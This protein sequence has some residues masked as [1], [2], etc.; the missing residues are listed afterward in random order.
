[1]GT[2]YPIW[3]IHQ[4][5]FDEEEKQRRQ[6]TERVYGGTVVPSS[7]PVQGTD[8]VMENRE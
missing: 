8:T 2:T 7:I 6:P 4:Q 5:G 1:M 3:P